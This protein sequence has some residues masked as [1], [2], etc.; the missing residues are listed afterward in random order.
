MSTSPNTPWQSGLSPIGLSPDSLR[1]KLLEEE[2]AAQR[3]AIICSFNQLLD[4][5]D[6]GTGVHSTRLA[7]WGMRVAQEL[8]LSEAALRDVEIA[9][10]LHDI[11]KIGVPD[12]I[13][14]KPGRLTDAEYDLMKKHPEFGWAVLRL[15]PGFEQVS[16]FI[17]HHHESFNGSGYPAG[18]SADEIP[19]G[20]R[21]VSVIDAFDAMVSDRP[22]RKGLPV[23][24]A[25]RRLHK[26][27]GTQFDADVVRCFVGIAS[28]EMQG[29]FAAAGTP[30]ASAV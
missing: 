1:V 24:E 30:S 15:F 29:V 8:N 9:A 4:L 19:V 27:S 23:E 2:L 26:D 10:L 20:S 7:E 14:N 5:K 25:V 13:L 12:S 18:L 17:L 16:L 3:N 28:H 11:G 22:Y 21:I 6:L